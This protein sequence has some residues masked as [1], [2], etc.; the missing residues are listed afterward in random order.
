MSERFKLTLY[1]LYV[2]FSRLKIYIFTYLC[3]CRAQINLSYSGNGPDM[4]GLV[5]SILEEPNK[6][7]PVTD[8]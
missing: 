4:V 3:F 5:S 2:L 1:L 8:W 7:E 6:A